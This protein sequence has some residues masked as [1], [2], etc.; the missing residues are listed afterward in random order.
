[1]CHFEAFVWST[2]IERWVRFGQHVLFWGELGG[3]ESL[4]A[5]NIG[6]GVEEGDRSGCFCHNISGLGT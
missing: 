5:K 2:D 1:M 4:Q 3:F 6:H